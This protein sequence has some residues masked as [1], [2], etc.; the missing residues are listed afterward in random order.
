MMSLRKD[1]HLNLKCLEAYKI[2]KNSF[3]L[4]WN[5]VEKFI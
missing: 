5:I 3:E 4:H 1:L 2:I